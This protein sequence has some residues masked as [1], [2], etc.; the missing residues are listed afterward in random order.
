MKNGFCSGHFFILYAIVIWLGGI[1]VFSSLFFVFVFLTLNLFAYF[2][3]NPKYRNHVL[4][5]FSLVFYSWGGPRYLILLLV[6]TLISWA[7]ARMIEAHPN[8]KKVF[9]WIECLS[10]LGLLGVF[11]YLGFICQN[12]HLDIIPN[13]ALPIGISF[14]TFQLLSYVIDVYRGLVQAQPVYWKLLLYS[15]LF[16]QCI[17]GPIVRYQTVV[18]E[19]DHRTIVFEDVYEGVRRFCV[20]LAKKAILANGCAMIADTLLPLNAKQLACQSVVGF[21]LGMICYMMQIYLDFSAYSDMAIGMG[22]MVGFHYLENF[23]YPYM[24]KSVQD[25]WKRWHISLSSFFRDYVYIPLGGSRCS[26]KR[27]IF[28][29][30]I[31]WLCTG[32]WHGASWNYVLWGMYYFVFLL[33][34]KF[35]IKDRIPKGWKHVYTLL[36]VLIGWVLFRFEDGSQLRIVIS[37]MI[38]FAKGGFVSLQV[39]TQFLQ[40]VFFLIV[41]G[42]ACTSLSKELRKYLYNFSQQNTIG[43]WMYNMVEIV[44]IPMLLILSVLALIG[45][46]YNPFLYFQF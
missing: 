9:L 19:I 5:V 28:N 38:G 23:N 33:L 4:L 6:E 37:G 20:G 25:F 35:V 1:M 17:A 14:Y 11:K 21:W 16:H 43:Y 13:I 30:F 27:W 10:L 26:Q 42:M 39:K 40:N 2:F 12:L 3:V 34:E 46:S 29:L 45:N 15:S 8:R 41:S 18:D 22:R 31:V 44:T 32:I 7:C 36:V 24:A